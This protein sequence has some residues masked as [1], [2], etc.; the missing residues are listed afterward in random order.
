[1]SIAAC[2][3]PPGPGSRDR[4]IRRGA[5]SRSCVTDRGMARDEVATSL[6]FKQECELRADESPT[7]S[8]DRRIGL[9]RPPDIGTNA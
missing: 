5:A 7:C 8:P 6:L 4:S 2:E 9:N 1:M 3:E